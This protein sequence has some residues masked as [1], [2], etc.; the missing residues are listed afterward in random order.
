M[1]TN[2][3]RTYKTSSNNANALVTSSGLWSA[4]LTLLGF[5]LLG[6]GAYALPIIALPVALLT[7]PN[8]T[9]E[10]PAAASAAMLIGSLALL[11]CSAAFSVA[12]TGFHT[13]PR[14]GLR[15]SGEPQV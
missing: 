6:Y 4:Y 1:T 15:L 12:I 2:F 7:S 14:P 10:V 3:H 9:N 13:K 8:S 11:A 5:L